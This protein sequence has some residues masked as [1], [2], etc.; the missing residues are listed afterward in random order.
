MSRV[1][2]SVVESDVWGG[3]E[4]SVIIGGKAVSNHFVPQDKY[5]SL[6]EQNPGDVGCYISELFYV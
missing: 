1:A 4:V 2:L 3:V 6:E 5:Q